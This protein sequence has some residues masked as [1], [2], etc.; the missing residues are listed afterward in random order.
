V[1]GCQYPYVQNE[2][3]SEAGYYPPVGIGFV[4]F[5]QSQVLSS[6]TPP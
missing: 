4:L 2:N 5:K 3:C 6:K 1:G